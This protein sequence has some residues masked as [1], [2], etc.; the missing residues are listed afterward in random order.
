MKMNLDFFG[1][2]DYVDGDGAVYEYT[3]SEFNTIIRNITGN[4]VVYG[5][6]KQMAVS[7]NGLTITIDTGIAFANGYIGQIKTA[8]S[9]T[10]NGAATVVMRVDVPNRTVSI[11]G[12]NSLTQNDLVY[13]LPLADV[14]ADGTITDRR[15]Y[16]YKPKEVMEKMNRITAG[17][18]TVYAR[19]A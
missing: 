8:K 18:E 4:G 5:E 10:L 11:I 14:A 13:D 2:F 9:I 15:E 12:V 16:I 1:L 19:Y 6:G 17:T 7:S 3:S